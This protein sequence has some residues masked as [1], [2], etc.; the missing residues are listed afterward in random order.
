M[1][2]KNTAASY[3]QVKRSLEE[4]RKDVTALVPNDNYPHDRYIIPALEEALG[5][6]EQGNFGVGAVLVDPSGDMIVRGH[7]H[8]FYPHFRSDIHAE[9][10]VMTKF[11]ESNKSTNSLKD[12]SLFTSLEPCPMCLTRLITSGIN[13]VYHAAEDV[14]SGMVSHLKQLTPIW[15][16]LAQEQEFEMARCSPALKELALEIFLFTATE[17]TK[18]LQE[19]RR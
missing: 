14:E 10:D 19:R 16:G 11:E 17:N 7:N 8:V 15:V 1:N 2:T 9:M 18:K 3:A 13:K 5:A 6:A 12:Y 4:L